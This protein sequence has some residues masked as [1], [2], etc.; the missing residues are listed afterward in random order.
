MAVPSGSYSLTPTEMAELNGWSFTKSYRD[1]KNHRD[2]LDLAKP[3]YTVLCRYVSAPPT[4]DEFC[5]A[6]ADSL[7]LTDLYVKRIAGNKF[8]LPL[9]LYDYFAELLAKYAVD[10]DWNTIRSTPCP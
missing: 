5:K 10:Q 3:L 8:Y 7:K 1:K 9:S 4:Q 2:L 6:Y